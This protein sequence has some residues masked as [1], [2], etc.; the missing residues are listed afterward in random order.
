MDNV[1]YLDISLCDSE[2]AL[3]VGLKA[4]VLTDIEIREVMWRTVP[5]RVFIQEEEC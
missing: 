1:T 2:I 3:K 4:R 5:E